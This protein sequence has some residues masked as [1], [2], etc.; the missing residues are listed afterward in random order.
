MKRLKD[1]KRLIAL[2]LAAAMLLTGCTGGAAESTEVPAMAGT[3]P[4]VLANAVLP[5]SGFSAEEDTSRFSDGLIGADALPLFLTGDNKN[6]VYSPLNIAMALAMLAEITDGETREEVLKVLGVESMEALRAK[7][8]KVLR[9]ACYDSEEGISLP[10]ASLWL[11]SDF[12]GYNAETMRTL[13][14]R[15]AASSYSGPMGTDEYNRLLQ[16]WINEQTKGLLKDQAGNVKLDRETV[17][18]LVTTLYYKAGWVQP[19]YEEQTQDEVFHS[20]D[21]DVTVPFLKSGT[22][23]YWRGE[24]FGAMRIPMQDGKWFWLF[25]PDE[26]YALSDI[27][28]DPACA[29]IINGEVEQQGVRV[30]YRFPKLDVTDET[31]LADLL[32]QLGITRAFDAQEADFSPL[33]EG[34]GPA[35]CLSSVKHAAR[36]TA[37]EYGVEAAAFT[38]MAVAGMAMI[39]DKPV[40]FVCDRPFLFAVAD[41][42]GLVW[43][44]GA[45]NHPGA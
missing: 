9:A 2:L 45:V 6:H 29:A 32:K 37:D 34:E 10:S 39:Q 21:G 3:E 43:F 16:D 41:D 38:V 18:A 44:A 4:K 12:D 42:N 14:N 1:H 13:A 31:D 28:A 26:G 24:H 25:L 35:T 7:V 11:R 27:T 30:N 8:E 40:E 17:L 5:D 19:F 36:L 15:Y 20:P 23:G 33:Y 22:H